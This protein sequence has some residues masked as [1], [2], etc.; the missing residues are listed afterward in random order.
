MKAGLA[1]IAQVIGQS[2]ANEARVVKKILVRIGYPRLVEVEI[3]QE[4]D[5]TAESTKLS[6]RPTAWI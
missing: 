2:F 3:I 5:R 4:E 6:P 1:N